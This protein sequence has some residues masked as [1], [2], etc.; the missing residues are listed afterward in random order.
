MLEGGVA[1]E[2]SELLKHPEKDFLG[3]ILELVRVSGEPRGSAKDAPL[4]ASDEDAEGIMIIAARGGD[5]RFISRFSPI[6][7]G[8]SR[9][10]CEK[11][12]QGKAGSHP[13]KREE[14]MRTK[15]SSVELWLP[16]IL[17]DLLKTAMSKR[18]GKH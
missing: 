9:I 1:A 12:G 16:G 6:G 14:L 17:A 8:I 5:E 4:M 7:C 10:G 13:L 15:T 3:E 11:I 2:L 18:P